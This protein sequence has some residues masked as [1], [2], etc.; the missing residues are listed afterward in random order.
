GRSTR[1]GTEEDII[2]VVSFLCC[3]FVC[4]LCCFRL[5]LFTLTREGGLVQSGRRDGGGHHFRGFFIVLPVC[6]PFV[7]F[8]LGAPEPFGPH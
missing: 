7:L 5:H 8:K 3:L 4:H 1:S 6:L 2:L